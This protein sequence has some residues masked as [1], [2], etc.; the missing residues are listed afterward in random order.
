VATL[1]SSRIRKKARLAPA[2]LGLFDET[3]V[4][5]AR[6]TPP[7]HLR[8]P[9]RNAPAAEPKERHVVVQGG[10]EFKPSDQAAH[11]AGSSALQGATS[12]IYRLS[13]LMRIFGY[14]DHDSFRN[15][16]R[17]AEGHGFPTPLPGCARPLKWDRGRVDAWRS[18][19][20][21]GEA[22]L[23]EPSASPGPE[24]VIALARERLRRKAAAARA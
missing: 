24:L 13:D 16:R 7:A 22:L 6:A 12:E 4:V 20:L 19:K 15:W 11:S 3:P 8:K 14:S 23:I 21:E 17:R 18:G 1:A 2:Q 10:G 5:S 9:G